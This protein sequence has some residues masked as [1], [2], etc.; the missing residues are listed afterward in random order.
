M[1][2]LLGKGQLS[3]RRIETE[4]TMLVSRILQVINLGNDFFPVKLTKE[5]DYEYYGLTEGLW[6]VSPLQLPFT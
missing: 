5:E 4:T 2:R 3:L 1:I 6:I